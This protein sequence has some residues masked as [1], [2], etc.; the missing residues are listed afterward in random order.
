[1]A[2]TLDEASK[3]SNDMML[4]S[5]YILVLNYRRTHDHEIENGQS[6]DR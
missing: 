2:L 4:V 1:M 5:V 3:L 6:L